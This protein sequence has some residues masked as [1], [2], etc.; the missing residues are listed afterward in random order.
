MVDVCECVLIVCV[1]VLIVCVCVDCV[2]VCVSMDV[3]CTFNTTSHNI[4]STFDYFTQ[5][6]Q[7]TSHN[8]HSTLRLASFPGLHAQ[9]LSLAVACKRWARRPED[10]AT[11]RP[12]SCEN[13][14]LNVVLSSLECTVN[15]SIVICVFSYLYN[16]TKEVYNIK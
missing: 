16:C 15:S 9:L 1:C 5:H 11:L 6:S 2:C 10:E 13:C 4:H 7:T 14:T 12:L 3:W 8:I